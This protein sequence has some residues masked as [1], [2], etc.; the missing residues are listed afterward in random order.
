MPSF[1]K[2]WRH[3]PHHPHHPTGPLLPLQPT[4]VLC[5]RGVRSGADQHAKFP[6]GCWHLLFCSDSFFFLVFFLPFK[7][8]PCPGARPPSSGLTLSREARAEQVKQERPRGQKKEQEK[9]KEAYEGFRDSAPPTSLPKF[10]C[11]NLN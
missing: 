9:R 10:R 5:M 11:S 7:A 1:G 2:S 6:S 4:P 3:H 8:E